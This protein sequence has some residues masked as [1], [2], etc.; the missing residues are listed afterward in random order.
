[1]HLVLN[2]EINSGKSSFVLSLV[3]RLNREGCKPSGFITAAHIENGEKIGHDLVIIDNGVM[4]EP[5]KFTRTRFF[6]G[7]FQRAKYHFNK[8]AFGAINTL[9][10]NTQ[11][12]IMDE[13]GPLETAHRRGFYSLMQ[14]VLINSQNTLSVIRKGLELDFARIANV[15]FRS[16]TLMEKD[17]LEAEIRMLIN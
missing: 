5:I 4:H 2:D 14:R 11:L 17:K 8:A 12:F 9:D 3:E 13:I 1:M 7:S 16:F 10:V 6:E 15:E